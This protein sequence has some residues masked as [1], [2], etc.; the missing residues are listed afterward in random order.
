MGRIY[1]SY[2]INFQLKQMQLLAYF[3]GLVQG[4]SL[5]AGAIQSSSLGAA[6][7]A[8]AVQGA[9]GILGAGA[10]LGARRRLNCT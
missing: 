9:S 8:G 2:S 3:S 10:V 4:A 7:G 6:L 1:S 5:G